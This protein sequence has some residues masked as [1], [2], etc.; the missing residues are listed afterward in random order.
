MSGGMRG[1]PANRRLR[2]LSK[3][4]KT[5]LRDGVY[6]EV[7]LIVVKP[8]DIAQ[9][10]DRLQTIFGKPS[11]ITEER[12]LGIE[13]QSADPVLLRQVVEATRG[14]GLDDGSTTESPLPVAPAP[15]EG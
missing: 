14:V 6:E 12:S 9:L 4:T 15:R 1:A 11:Q 3:K 7:P 2:N 8:Q 13:L 5:V 10:I